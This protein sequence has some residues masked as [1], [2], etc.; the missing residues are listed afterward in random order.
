MFCNHQNTMK[1]VIVT[2]GQQLLDLIIY[3]LSCYL[4]TLFLYL[5]HAISVVAYYLCTYIL[6][7]AYSLFFV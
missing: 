6:C 2:L 3:P 4:Y 7:I 1:R 5:F